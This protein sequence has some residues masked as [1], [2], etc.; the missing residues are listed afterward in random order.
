MLPASVVSAGGGAAAWPM[1]GDRRQVLKVLKIEREQETDP[2][3]SAH[4][5]RERL[6]VKGGDRPQLPFH[7]RCCNKRHRRGATV[8]PTGQIQY[9][10]ESTCGAAFGALA[11]AVLEM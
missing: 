5:E 7:A 2:P 6:A 11:G 3:L 9:F 10:K 8:D 4:Q 1:P